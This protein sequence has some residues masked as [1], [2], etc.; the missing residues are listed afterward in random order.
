[1]HDL[2]KLAE[3]ET[4]PNR[5]NS[6]YRKLEPWTPSEVAFERVSAK[7]GGVQRFRA[8]L[9]ELVGSGR[10][11]VQVAGEGENLTPNSMRKTLRDVFPT[12]KFR[13]VPGHP[14]TAVA[15]L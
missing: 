13:R 4:N 6:I 7:S 2:T 10:R 5:P 3:A 11:Y 1:M 8:A 9:K 12:L 14:L 15:F